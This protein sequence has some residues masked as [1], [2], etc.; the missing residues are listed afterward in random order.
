MA[1]SRINVTFSHETSGCLADLAKAT[2]KPVQELAEKLIRRA[3]DEVEDIALSQI[4]D[5]CDTPDMDMIRS[6][7]IDWNTVLKDGA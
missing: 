3:I 4:V 1:D 5:E 2:K 6:K 7:D